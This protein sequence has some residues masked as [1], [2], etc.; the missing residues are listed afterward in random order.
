MTPPVK[1]FLF[2]VE[3]LYGGGAEKVL[4]NTASLLK[5]AGVDVTLFTLREK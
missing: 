5:D 1:K 3:D 2:I 4:L